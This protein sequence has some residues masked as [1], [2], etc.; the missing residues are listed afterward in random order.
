MSTAHGQFT[1]SRNTRIHQS[2][3]LSQASHG[4]HVRCRCH[5]FLICVSQGGDYKANTVTQHLQPEGWPDDRL[6]R[7]FYCLQ[8][9]RAFEVLLALCRD[10]FQNNLRLIRIL[11]TTGISPD[12]ILLAKDR[13]DTNSR[14]GADP[15][16]NEVDS[17][18]KNSMKRRRNILSYY[19]ER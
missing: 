2:Q 14:D 16:Q 1:I 6:N 12:G 13:I 10:I 18:L 19:P 17:S 7:E 8:S 11:R 4:P 9:A 3:H 5:T 15:Y